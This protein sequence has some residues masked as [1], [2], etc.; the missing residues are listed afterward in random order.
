VNPIAGIHRRADGRFVVVCS[1]GWHDTNG[2]EGYDTKA[3]A[4]PSK[5]GH[6]LLAHS[7]AGGRFKIHDPQEGIA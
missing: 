6:R 2:G 5:D 4:K 3:H 7:S 1:C